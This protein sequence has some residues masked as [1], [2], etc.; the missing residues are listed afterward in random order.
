MEPLC[1]V[2][3]LAPFLLRPV[4]GHLRLQVEKDTFCKQVIAARVA[5]GH[6]ESKKIP[7][8]DD[9]ESFQVSTLKADRIHGFMGGFPCQAR[10]RFGF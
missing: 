10:K 5:E 3:P 9:V 4:F 8:Y 2:L 6:F 7:I 1:F